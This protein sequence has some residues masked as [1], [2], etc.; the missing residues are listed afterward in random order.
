MIKTKVENHDK[1]QKIKRIFICG[2]LLSKWTSAFQS[3]LD[4]FSIVIW[5]C[6][7]KITFFV[8]SSLCIL[9]LQ[10]LN[11]VICSLITLF[12]KCIKLHQI[13]SQFSTINLAQ[14][15]GI[16]IFRGDYS[17][18]NNSILSKDINL[19]YTR[20]IA[21]NTN[22]IW[23]NKKKDSFG[24]TFSK[25]HILPRIFLNIVPKE[26]FAPSVHFQ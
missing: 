5:A 1:N 11:V 14:E 8:F 22:K 20:F 21:E 3:W 4:C 2:S 12:Y 17:N 6:I 10:F 26:S 15:L 7:Q 13:L 18:L 19:Q 16:N 23:C 9:V 24:T 25:N